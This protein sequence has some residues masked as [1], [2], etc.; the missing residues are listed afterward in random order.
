MCLPYRK[1]EQEDLINKWAYLI[2][3]AHSETVDDFAGV[4]DKVRD[5]A[6]E[7]KGID[8]KGNQ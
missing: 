2:W 3:N 1:S 5:F 7:L 6:K 8:G 4:R